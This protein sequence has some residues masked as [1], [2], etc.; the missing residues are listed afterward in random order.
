M[1]DQHDKPQQPDN[2]PDHA[3]PPGKPFDM[4]LELGDKTKHPAAKEPQPVDE[5]LEVVEDAPIEVQEVIE[6]PTVEEVVEVQDVVEAPPAQPEVVETVEEVMEVVEEPAAK[7][8]THA[9]EAPPAQAAA[10][11]PTEDALDVIDQPVVAGSHTPGSA[12]EVKLGEDAGARV[13]EMPS[14]SSNVEL[15]EDVPAEAPS[16]S[17]NVEL[18]EDVPAASSGSSSNIDLVEEAAAAAPPSGSSNVELVEEVVESP[19]GSSKVDLVEEVAKSPSSSSKVDLVEEVVESPSGSS[20]IDLVEEVGEGIEDAIDEALKTPPPVKTKVPGKPVPTMLAGKEKELPGDEL[21]APPPKSAKRKEAAEE[22]MDVVD[23]VVEEEEPPPP[24]ARGGKT[25]VSGRGPVPTMLAQAG[26]QDL[27]GE[28]LRPPRS[29]KGAAKKPAAKPS[30]EDALEDAL[31]VVETVPSSSALS[32]A[33]LVETDEHRPAK[34]PGDKSTDFGGKEDSGKKKPGTDKGT[35]EMD[36]VVDYAEGEELVEGASEVDLGRRPPAKGERPSGVDIIAEALESGVDLGSAKSHTPPQGKKRKSESQLDLDAGLDDSAESSAIDLGSSDQRPALPSSSARQAKHRGDEEESDL[37]SADE[38]L[39]SVD[40]SD[41]VDSGVGH[42]ELVA[43]QKKA[44]GEE[45]P[46][47]EDVIDIEEPMDVEEEAVAT[48]KP[49]KTTARPVAEEEEELLVKPKGAAAAEEEEEMLVRPKGAAEVQEEEPATPR[50][51]GRRIDEGEEKPRRGGRFLPFVAGGVA[52]V[53]LLAGAAAGVWFANKNLVLDPLNLTEKKA[54]SPGTGTGTGPGPQAGPKVP[55]ELAPLFAEYEQ[56]TPKGGKPPS[57][58]DEKVKKLIEKAEE[59]GGKSLAGAFQTMIEDRSKIANGQKELAASKTREDTLKK[60]AEKLAAD[61][62]NAEKEV[63]DLQVDVT[64]LQNN[65]L[66]EKKQNKDLTDKLTQANVALDKAKTALAA[67]TKDLQKTAGER[68]ALNKALSA[69]FKELEAANYLVKDPDPAK[70]MVESIKKARVAAQSPLGST[71]GQVVG[72]LSDM[73]KAPGGWTKKL[74][75]TAKLQQD[76][77]AAQAREAFAER[78]EKRLD[79]MIVLLQDRNHKEADALD[80]YDRFA[81]W[82]LQ[83]EFKASPL[84]KAKAHYVEALILRNKEDYES[85]RKGLEQTLAEAKETPALH[86]VVDRS[87]KEL[88]EPTAYYLPRA[89]VKAATGDVK[90]AIEELNT[91]LKVMP[92]DQ[93]QLRLQRAQLTF[94]AGLASGKLDEGTQKQIRDD[95]A[96]AG[97]DKALAGKSFYLLGRLDENN[98]DWVRAEKNYRQ[99]IEASNG[100]PDADAYKV[101][102]ARVLLRDRAPA[103]GGGAEGDKGGGTEESEAPLNEDDM[104][105]T[106]AAYEEQQDEDNP[107]AQKRLKE[108]MEIANVLIKSDNPKTRGEGYMLLGAAQA[109]L[110]KKNEGLLNYVK[111]LELVY[112]GINTEELV[113]M[114]NTHPAF[115]QSDLALQVNPVMSERHFAKGLEQFWAKNYPAA[116]GE[117]KKAVSF[118]NEDARYYYFLGMSQYLQKSKQKVADAEYSIELGVKLEIARKPASYVINASLERIQGE[119]RRMLNARRE[120]V[121]TAG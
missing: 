5:V 75:D 120:K 43:P 37:V 25:R 114:V 7:A 46:A 91:A 2:A 116:E 34:K 98:K 19:S 76:L 121:A 93:P 115:Q 97:K 96:A 85:A 113:K 39:E 109:R 53:L 52:A 84:M 44:R 66:A 65:I 54:T 106:S 95:A 83:P 14:G 38:A 103:E 45:P 4:N 60:E 107:E 47:D 87:L 56:L 35:G 49:R 82:V 16:G 108:S 28:E 67:V 11:P 10:A 69:G 90:G 29:G 73:S 1:A 17:S 64:N 23:E 88:T 112:P 105:L 77:K 81:K 40:E 99:A 22:V 80:S 30:E 61:K 20:K 78:P 33:P 79:S 13:K 50:G 89:Q 59:V 74:F 48:P 12:S 55:D 62:A 71:L 111:G 68:D 63:A 36:V 110:G 8:E 58:K 92:S 27:P 104:Y 9:A 100:S 31:D 51:K 86:A 72:T 42:E 57:P 70:Q 119:L 24:P 6:V 102:L 118:F 3:K 117:F 32:G 41:L 15:V 18:V 21:A 94:D 26:D 101:A